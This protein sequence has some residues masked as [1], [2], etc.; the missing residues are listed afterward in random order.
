MSA[1]KVLMLCYYYPPLETAGCARS[2]A[3]S[4]NLP[5][6][7]WTPVVL[8]VATAHDSWGV[9]GRAAPVPNDVR[10]ERAPELDLDRPVALADAVHHRVRTGLGLPAGGYRFR[11]LMCVPDPHI[12]WRV[13]GPGRRLARGC[14]CLY[15]TCSPFS[16]ALAAASIKRRTGLPLVLDFR[17][18]WTLNPHVLADSA[19]YRWRNRRLERRALLAADRV[20]FNTDG[21]LRMYR[22]AWP[23]LADRFTCIPNGHDGLNLPA[24]ED[25]ARAGFTVVHVGSLYGTRDPSLLLAAMAELDLPGARFVQVGAAHAACERFRDRVAIEVTGQVAHTEA[26]AW[27]R[28][29]SLLYLRQGRESHAD[30]SPA[31]AAKT[32]EYLATGMPILADCPP[33]DNAD[34]VERY[35]ARAWVIRKDDP[36]AL[37]AA[38]QA[39]YADHQAWQPHVLPAFRDGFSR[40]ALTARLAGEFDLACGGEAACS[41]RKL[42]GVA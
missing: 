16:S 4:R 29:A 26:L 3:F 35:A 42:E 22:E 41:Q 23:E 21:A 36:T 14:D 2:V 1:R 28:R 12:A 39:A 18:A 30:W 32:H 37:R 11:E 33:G 5:A 8:T 31:V 13:R 20:I 17:D 15:A 24:P 27:M 40:T 25:T 9:A 7:G 38:L 34:L 10:V 6:H 19:L